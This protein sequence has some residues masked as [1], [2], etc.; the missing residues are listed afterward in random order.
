ML[1][2]VEHVHDD[3]FFFGQPLQDR[4]GSLAHDSGGRMKV[5]EN[6]LA[7]L[8]DA[9]QLCGSHM[10]VIPGIRGFPVGDGKDADDED[11]RQHDRA[12]KKPLLSYLPI[13]SACGAP[14][15]C[16]PRHPSAVRR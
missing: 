11:R 13:A 1:I 2:H 3:F 10:F 15:L 12:D 7:A 4:S 9:V 14:A 5:Y 6:R 8:H 16:H